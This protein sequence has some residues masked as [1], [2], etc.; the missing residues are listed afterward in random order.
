MVEARPGGWLTLAEAATASG[1]NPELLRRWCVAGRLP[2]RRVGRDWVIAGDD[3]GAVE[4]MPRRGERRPAGLVLD[5][6][7]ILS[8]AVGA[9]VRECLEPDETVRVVLAGAEDSALVVTSRRAFVVRDGV[10]VTDP[11]SG[12]V[13][14]WPLDR[15]RRGQLE[16]GA[17]TGALVLTPADPDDRALV[18]VLARP[19]LARASVATTLLRELLQA[20]GSYDQ[21]A[22]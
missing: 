13:A 21:D 5:D 12:L 6:L 4:R 7:S 1:R 22:R 14:A 11:Q 15:I 17:A 20:A 8:S 9:G 2:C 10:L 16:A 19:H 3:M 18:L